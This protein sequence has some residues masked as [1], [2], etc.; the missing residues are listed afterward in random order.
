MA[1][2]KNLE[3]VSVLK[4]QIQQKSCKVP[5]SPGGYR[6]WFTKD[7][8]QLLLKPFGGKIN[9]SKIQMRTF[10]DKPYYALYVGISKNLYDRLKWHI[11]QK[12]SQSAVNSGFLSTL[13]QTVS[14]LLG[15]DQTKSQN[16]VS[17]LLERCYWE[18]ETMPNPEMWEKDELQQ[19][20]YY[21]P[22]NLQ[23]NQS[24]PKELQKELSRLRKYYKK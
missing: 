2:L 15:I 3:K 13:R 23:N 1:N 22:L 5:K 10:D 14:A 12:H 24:F 11:F 6:W 9:W 19:N 7:D 16:C 17:A 20:E 21:Y 4:Q 8:A 18:W